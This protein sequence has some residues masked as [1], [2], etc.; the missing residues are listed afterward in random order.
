MLVKCAHCRSNFK[1]TAKD[2][3]AIGYDGTHFCSRECLIGYLSIRRSP[4]VSGK[5]LPIHWDY[6]S[7]WERKFADFL[8][9]YGLDFRYEPYAFLLPNQKWYIPDF[10]VNGHMIEIK[11]VWEA[12]ARKKAKLYRKTVGPLIVLSEAMLKLLEIIK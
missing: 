3:K 4:P 9:S 12:G 11:G 2:L 5:P 7:E 6:K 1:A 8:T 10:L